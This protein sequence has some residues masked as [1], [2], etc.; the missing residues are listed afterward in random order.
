[1]MTEARFSRPLPGLVAEAAR[2]NPFIVPEKID[3]TILAPI[4]SAASE[5]AL[6]LPHASHDEEA[7]ARNE[8]E[9][10]LE[11]AGLKAPRTG[12][13]EA[14]LRRKGSRMILEVKAASPSKD[15][16][17]GTVDLN[18]YANVY[19]RYADAVSVLTEPRFFGGSF[20]RLAALRLL[21]D[22]PLLAKD[23][24]VS[25]EQILAACRSGADA[26][27][28]MLSVLSNEGYRLLADYAQSLGLEILTE[29]S[30]P[31]EARHA[32]EFGARVI[33]INN[34]NLRTLEVDLS[35]APAIAEEI[36][37]SPVIVAESGY[38]NAADILKARA[39]SPA[40]NAF[41]CGSALSL[42]GDLS[43]GVRELLYG[44]SKC[45]GITRAEDA[46]NALKAGAA[47]IGI[48]LAPRSKRA[49]TLDQAGRLVKEIRR[50]AREL[51]LSAEIA[52]VIDAAQLGEVSAIQAALEPDV[53]QIHGALSDD[54]LRRLHSDFPAFRLAPAV[55]PEGLSPDELEKLA[56]RIRELMEE[57]TIDRAVLDSASAGQTGGT[58]RS[59]DFSLLASFR[60]I[61]R[62]VIAGGLSKANA[63]QAAHAFGENFF[64]LDFNSGVEDAPGIK[65][66]EKLRDA[67]GAIRGIRG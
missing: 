23:F 30:T 26:V 43:T 63:A 57:K 34:R 25:R 33:G 62:I 54:A 11:K 61:P 64:G 22:K 67:F 12:C 50:G 46:L 5:R 19:G 21:T 9:A 51:G 15:L 4:V 52:A 6:S 53:L 8:R 55:S 47:A 65:S 28:L 66:T 56:R 32:A 2:R 48:I 17:R 35:R 13:F 37:G 38:R 24:I 45:C 36:P 60:D 29:A 59:F 20:E 14:A 39:E 1:M 58:G 27:L 41:L 7:R 31:E 49:V 40:I 3:G 18:D 44:H 16:M 10:L 42:A